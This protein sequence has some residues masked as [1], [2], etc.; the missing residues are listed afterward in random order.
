MPRGRRA[1]TFE[2]VTRTEE[3]ELWRKHSACWAGSIKPTS[4]VKL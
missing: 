1:S 3:E 4:T 2:E